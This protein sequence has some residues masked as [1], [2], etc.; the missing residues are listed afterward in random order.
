MVS[1]WKWRMRPL[2]WCRT[3]TTQVSHDLLVSLPRLC[4]LTIAQAYT[5]RHVEYREAFALFDKRGT[6]QVP[7]ESLGELLRSLG[8]N[9]TQAEIAQLEQSVGASCE[10]ICSGRDLR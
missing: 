4:P 2:I 10:W 6:G 3:T 9:P 5:D 1:G 7:G 8:Q